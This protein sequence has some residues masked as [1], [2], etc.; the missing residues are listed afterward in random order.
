MSNLGGVLTAR[1]RAEEAEPLIREA[2]TRH[3]SVGAKDIT[4]GTIRRTLGECLAA[5]GR[6]REA[7]EM[8]LESHRVLTASRYAERH[9]AETALRLAEFYEAR[10][11][12]VDANRFRK[13]AVS[14]RVG[15]H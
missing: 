9:R 5:L 4:A 1:G 14:D 11:R 2:L 8:L 7:E 15:P 6:D 12:R 3:E 13:L 10:G